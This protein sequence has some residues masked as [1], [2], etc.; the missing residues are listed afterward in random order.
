MEFAADDVRVNDSV[1]HIL[2]I[3][4]M[5]IIIT[6]INMSIAGPRWIHI[7]TP[8]HESLTQIVHVGIA[9]LLQQQHCPNGII[10]ATAHTVHWVIG[11]VLRPDPDL[12][13]LVGQIAEWDIDRPRQA[14]QG[15]LCGHA[16]VQ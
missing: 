12:V 6:I 8:R 1:A 2:I 5:I 4:L 16:H 7:A 11:V 13:Q 14:T 15:K 3:I 10:A 9:L